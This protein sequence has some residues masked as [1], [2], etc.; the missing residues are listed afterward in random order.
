M[1]KKP[2]SSSDCTGEIEQDLQELALF[3]YDLF[4]ETVSV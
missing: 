1:A 3:L 2:D 4:K